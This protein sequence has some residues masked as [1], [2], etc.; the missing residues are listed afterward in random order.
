MS[1]I[2]RN[3]DALIVVDVQYDFLP[4]GTLAVP[5]GD[6][7]IPVIN[8]LLPAFSKIITTQDWHPENHIS[9]KAQGGIW[10]PHCV[11]NTHG[12]EIHK[13]LKVQNTIHILKGNNPDFEAYSGFQ[14]TD[15]SDRLHMDGV[16]TVYIAGL[17]TDYCVKNTVLDALNHRF[18]TYVITDAIRGVEVKPGDSAKALQEMEAA[19]AGIIESSD[20][21]GKSLKAIRT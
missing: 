16:T 11:Q 10:P 20:I 1:K 3:T 5:E 14:G 17:A 19:G 6:L 15:L 12:A 21:L 7:V 18:E 4:G 9:F 8:K 2:D 13:D